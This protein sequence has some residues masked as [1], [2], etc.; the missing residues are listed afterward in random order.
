MSNL[1]STLKCNTALVSRQVLKRRTP[2]APFAEDRSWPVGDIRAV[3]QLRAN[4][5]RS[6]PQDLARG[7]REPAWC[8][9]MPECLAGSMKTTSTCSSALPRH[10]R[11][12]VG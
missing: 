2:K 9:R 1:K 5:G 11:G 3:H 10:T 8:A 7:M 4:C 6:L 12:W